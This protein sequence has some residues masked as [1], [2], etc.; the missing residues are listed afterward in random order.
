MTHNNKASCPNQRVVYE[1]TVQ[2]Q[3]DESWSAWFSGMSIRIRE[4]GPS[5]T[6]LIGPVVDQS[7][8]RGILERIW[9]LNLDLISVQLLED[10]GTPRDAETAQYNERGGGKRS[11]TRFQ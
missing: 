10:K 9:N 11:N 3:I 4:G 1:I 5:L 8:L 7:A 2:G 6:K